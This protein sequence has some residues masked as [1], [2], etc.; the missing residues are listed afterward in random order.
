LIGE[1]PNFERQ[2]AALLV[3]LLP[4]ASC[5]LPLAEFLGK[6][7]P[8]RRLI[9]NRVRCENNEHGGGGGLGLEARGARGKTA[10]ALE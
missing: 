8:Q 9:L 10:C 6:R 3:D 7:S 1:E 2:S 4:F 5:L